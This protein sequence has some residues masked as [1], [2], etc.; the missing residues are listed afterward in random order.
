M[1]AGKEA[2]KSDDPAVIKNA[3]GKIKVQVTIAFKKLEG[4]LAKKDD[5]FDHD[6][7]SELEV[8]KY[9]K[10]LKDN[11]ELF[12]SLHQRYCFMRPVFDNEAKELEEQQ[13]DFEYFDETEQKYDNLIKLYAEYTDNLNKYKDEKKK[14]A[15]LE[16]EVAA[17]TLKVPNLKKQFDFDL[18]GYHACV[19]SAVTKLKVFTDKLKTGVCDVAF[20]ADKIYDEVK[21]IY[22]SIKKSFKDLSEAMNMKGVEIKVTAPDF[23]YEQESAKIN[24]LLTDL[25]TAINTIKISKSKSGSADLSTSSS[26]AEPSAVKVAK[27][28]SIKFSGQPR[29]FADFYKEFCSVIVPHRIKA[30]IGIYLRQAIPEQ[31]RHLLDNIELDSWEDMMEVLKE[32]FGTSKLVTSNVLADLRKIKTITNDKGFVEFVEKVER[33]ERNMKAIGL[34]DQLSNAAVLNELEAKLPQVF[35]MDWGRKVE[36]GKLNKGHPSVKF[37]SFMEFLKSCKI[38]LRIFL[39]PKIPWL[40]L[41]FKL[42]LL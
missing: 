17:L 16:S 31:Y 4:L 8:T 28:D 23:S 39:F 13:T 40:D 2:L 35:Y 37:T 38:L 5:R 32:K 10:K 12:E 7:I 36:A 27:I 6:E 15:K 25:Q 20:P 42:I 41:L 33:A 24:D 1:S 26:R 18:V 34:L 11:Y 19:N 22:Q 3:R 9:H 30:E 29:D 14:V 21:E